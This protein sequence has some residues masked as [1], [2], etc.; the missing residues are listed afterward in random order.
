MTQASSL[1]EL[2]D[3]WGS[4]RGLPPGFGLHLLEACP[5]LDGKETMSSELAPQ[6]LEEAIEPYGLSENAVESLC[7]T[8]NEY[9]DRDY[10]SSI[11][12]RNSAYTAIAEL[13]AQHGSLG[14]GKTYWLVED[15]FSTSTPCIVVKDPSAL[16]SALMKEVAIEVSRC[17]QFTSVVFSDEDGNN[18]VELSAR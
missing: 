12:A 2:L 7:T 6:L 18:A 14:V 3:E 11:P 17:P 8:Y 1:I 16:S 15:S 9:V 10:L 13:L 5:W 4:A